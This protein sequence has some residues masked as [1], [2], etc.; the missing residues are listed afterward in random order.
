MPAINTAAASSPHVCIRRVPCMRAPEKR[1]GSL[2]GH[3]LILSKQG[4]IELHLNFF[5]QKNRR[6]RHGSWS[7]QMC[8][9]QQKVG[10]IQVYFM[11][12]SIC[13]LLYPCLHGTRVRTS[14]AGIHVKCPFFLF[15]LLMFS[16]VLRACSALFW[17]DEKS[18]WNRRAAE[19]KD[20]TNCRIPNPIFARFCA[21]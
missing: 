6:K 5:L 19:E 17:G 16:L 3:E 7:A 11:K 2:S 13:V 1:G 21:G 9:C 15:P 14:N 12:L 4:F 20:S 10:G 8:F 18:A